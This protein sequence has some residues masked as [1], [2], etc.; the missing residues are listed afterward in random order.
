MTNKICEGT[1]DGRLHHVETLPDRQTGFLLKC[2][3]VLS[4]HLGRVHI[5]RRLS[6][7]FG[8]H[9]HHAQEDFLYALDWGPALAARL[10]AEGVIAR[11]VEDTEVTA[12]L[13]VVQYY[14]II[15]QSG[16]LSLLVEIR[17]DTV[18]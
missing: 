3:P 7:W 15:K 18:L 10:V 8:Q 5:G 11:G 1:G 16:A 4:P 9:G 12:T 6:V 17:R 14:Y 2:G 13:E